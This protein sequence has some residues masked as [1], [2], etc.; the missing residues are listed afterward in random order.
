[1]PHRPV[2]RSPAPEVLFISAG[3]VQYHLHKVFAKFAINS[4]SQVDRVLPDDAAATD[5]E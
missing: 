1:M 3:T 5:R 4:R 2:S